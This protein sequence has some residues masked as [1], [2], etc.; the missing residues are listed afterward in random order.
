V[1]STSPN[2]RASFVS[3]HE[4]ALSLAPGETEMMVEATIWGML[5]YG[6]GLIIERGGGRGIHLYS[7]VGHLLVFL[8]HAKKMTTAFSYDGPLSIDITLRG[9]RDVPWLYMP[10]G[11]LCQGPLSVLDDTFSFSLPTTSDMLREQSDGT[12]CGN[13]AI[14]SVRYELGGSRRRFQYSRITFGGWVPAQLVEYSDGASGQV[15]QLTAPTSLRYSPGTS[16]H[17]GCTA[18]PSELTYARSDS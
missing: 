8:E 12:R 13:S 3:Q 11:V 10:D 4:S 16:S 15:V 18:A 7:L 5:F 17:P 1:E 6:A 2:P 9:I 14:Y